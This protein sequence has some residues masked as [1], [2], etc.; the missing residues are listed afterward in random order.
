[1]F[2][3]QDL[4]LPDKAT[5]P[6]VPTPSARKPQAGGSV[7]ALAS[8]RATGPSPLGRDTGGYDSRVTAS[9]PEMGAAAV[10]GGALNTG[11][12]PGPGPLLQSSAPGAQV[13]H[14]EPSYPLSVGSQPSGL[15]LGGGPGVMPERSGMSVASQLSGGGSAG[16]YGS[17]LPPGVTA[18]G[19]QPGLPPGVTAIGGQPGL[20]PGV[21]AMGGQPGLPP[22]VTSLG[23][24]PGLPPGVHRASATGGLPPGV[25]RLSPEPS[26]TPPSAPSPEPSHGAYPPPG[27]QQ[28]HSPPVQQH[29]AP[30]PAPAAAAAPPP[31]GSPTAF[32]LPPGAPAAVA[33]TQAMPAPPM[34]HHQQQ[35]QPGMVAIHPAVLNVAGSLAIPGSGASTHSPG[36]ISLGSRAPME[37][38]KETLVKGLQVRWQLQ[39]ACISALALLA[40]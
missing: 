14:P 19:G 35:Q 39:G 23:P 32:A 6:A 2:T 5:S 25:Q 24:Q 8:Q 40:V 37:S 17:G 26:S 21:T 33:V 34:Q 13:L 18:M 28:L 30:A 12:V 7:H 29:Y 15:S 9:V 38:I 20:P 1:M 11:M 22:G 31:A 10:T 27:V 36:E 16:A 3:L 4:P